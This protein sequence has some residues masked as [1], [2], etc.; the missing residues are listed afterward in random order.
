MNT[1]NLIEDIKE[2]DKRLP[3]PEYRLGKE[4]LMPFSAA[5]SGARK[6]MFSTHQDHCMSLLKPEVPLISTGFESQFGK[7]S[8]TFTVADYDAEVVA[9]IPKYK[10]I[11]KLHYFMII[12]KDNGELDVLTRVSYNHITETY[13]YLFNTDYLDAKRIGDTIKREDVI[14]KSRSFDE[15]NNRM[16]GV[17]LRTTYLACNDNTEDA[18]ILAESAAKKFVSPLIK[19]VS[20]IINDNDILLNLYGDDNHYKVIPD[21]GQKV[22]DGILAAV[23]REN[24]DEA[25]YTQSYDRLRTIMMSDEKYIAPEKV[26]DIDVYCNN[27]DN[28]TDSIYNEQLLYY[29][30]E[31]L[32]WCRDLISSVDNMRDN[33]Y[34]KLSYNLQKLYSNAVKTLEGKKFNKTKP[35]SNIGIDITVLEELTFHSGDKIANRYGG[36]GV[37]GKIIPDE[38]MPRLKNGDVIECIYNQA[39]GTNRLNMSQFFEYEI[40]HFSSSLIEWLSTG[41]DDEGAFDVA[42]TVRVIL[43]FI[44]ILNPEQADYWENVISCMDDDEMISF[45]NTLCTDKGIMLSL[46]PVTNNATIHTLEKL[47]DT[48]PFIKQSDIWVYIKGSDG[49]PRY[50]KAARPIVVGYEYIYRLKQ[51]AEEKFSTTSLSSINIRGENSR[52]KAAA[53]FKDIRTKTPVRFGEMETMGAA[54]LGMDAVV[55]ML[56]L[57]ATSPSARRR[58]EELLTNKTIDVDVKLGDDDSSRIVE[59]LNAYLKTMGL[60]LTFEKI[61][62]LKPVY[63]RKIIK[64]DTLRQVYYK[65]PYNEAFDDPF[66]Q[67]NPDAP[68]KFYVRLD[69]MDNTITVKPLRKLYTFSQNPEKDDPNFYLEWC[70]H[71]DKTQPKEELFKKDSE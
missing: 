37:V 33:G 9:I 56:M 13:G 36:K 65:R 19:K 4:L 14:Q 35:F 7:H 8:S 45:I 12:L 11:P 66:H 34:T 1:L 39:T 20:L 48:F 21:I 30:N 3:L 15:F 68:M 71:F 17:N 28:I 23:R 29:W 70:R 59:T 27:L 46:M 32:R 18:I 51:Y 26:I 42:D 58:V 5:S 67:D 55:F 53:Q 57:N 10:D 63:L 24:K 41:G 2:V 62:K 25:F 54:H 40:N 44:R 43:K 60:K 22:K 6:L 49:N 16:D 47:M 64:R 31:R 61:P 52:S 69:H 50:V 38:K